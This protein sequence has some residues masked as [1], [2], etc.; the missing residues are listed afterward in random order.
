M[1][2]QNISYDK[3]RELNQKRIEF[4][5]SNREKIESERKKN[6]VKTSR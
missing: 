1:K 6:F 5:Q 2:N 4:W 3:Q